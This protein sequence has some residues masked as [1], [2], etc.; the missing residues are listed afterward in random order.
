[1]MC[2][3]FL[4]KKCTLKLVKPFR[5]LR[6][7][8]KILSI[9]FG[10]S[11]LDLSTVMLAIILNNQIMYYGGTAAL[12]VYGIVGT[13]SSLFQALFCGVGQAVQPLAS[14]NYGAKKMDR[15]QA[16]LR[17]AMITSIIMGVIFTI[18]GQAFPGQIVRLFTDATPEVLGVAP[19]IIRGY[20]IVFLFLGINVLATY[21]LQSTMHGHLS[22]VI[23]ILRGFVLSTIFLYALPLALKLSGVC[24][25]MP[26]SECLTAVIALV[27][28]YKPSTKKMA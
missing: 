22:A 25:A 1:I 4:S 3:H 26:V 27:L 19:I 8:H 28:I 7:I 11:L 14:A 15:T 18:V 16:V 17:M 2:S 13:I 5:P 12:S 10:S 9:G 23:A 21:F 20:F 6:A 24:I